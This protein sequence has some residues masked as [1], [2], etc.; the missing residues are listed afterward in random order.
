MYT[1]RKFFRAK[2]FFL[3]IPEVEFLFISIHKFFATFFEKKR[4]RTERGNFSVHYNK[5]F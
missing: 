5:S 2:S 4:K 1:R 3:E